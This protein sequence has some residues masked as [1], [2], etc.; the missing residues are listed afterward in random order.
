[1]PRRT[2]R[3]LPHTALIA[4]TALLV[5]ACAPSAQAR[6]SP[7]SA[8][9][10][11]IQ[12]EDAY[13]RALPT[14]HHRG[15]TYVLGQY[16]TK[17]TVRVSNHTNQRIEAVLTVDGR[18]AISGDLGDYTRQR[19]YVIDP[20]GSVVVD[21]FRQSM[22]NVAAFRFTTPGD[23]YTGRRG[24]AQHAGVIGVA[25]FREQGR[26]VAV[27]PPP[28]PPHW[29]GQWGGGFEGDD[30]AQ[31]PRGEAR[32]SAPA[33]TDSMADSAEA[34]APAVGGAVRSRRPSRPRTSNNLGT[35]YGESQ[36]SPVVEV[37]FRRARQGRPDHI[38]AVYYDDASGLQNRGIPVYSYAPP[39]SPDPFP[40]DRRFAPAPY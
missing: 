4:L 10:Y 39:P 22:H 14:Y 6:T 36:Y 18:D 21:G 40:T 25:V 28:Q 3:H 23:S 15:S 24:T 17:Y 8:G 33:P 32:K 7:A 31:A 34:E 5:T 38:L 9:G 20:Y 29:R 1:M 16:D 19:G 26:P 35:R 11:S 2:S 13:G 37:P 27:A 30:L 12:I